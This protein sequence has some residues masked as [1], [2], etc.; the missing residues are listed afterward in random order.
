MRFGLRF[1]RSRAIGDEFLPMQSD[2]LKQGFE[3]ARGGGGHEQPTTDLPFDLVDGQGAVDLVRRTGIEK[4]L[5][6]DVSRQG[7]EVIEDGFGPEI[8]PCGVPG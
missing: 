8:L 1:L 4:R 2:F 7:I 6:G 5:G 3:A